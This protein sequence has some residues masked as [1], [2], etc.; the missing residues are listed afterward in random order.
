[1]V[2]KDAIEKGEWAKITELT[3][4]AV[5][6]MLGFEL[7]HVGIN[8]GSPEKAMEDATM[9]AKFLG[10]EINDGAGAAFVGNGFE[11]LKKPFKGT[12]GHLAIATNSV[13]RAKW[14]LERRGFQFEDE[15]EASYKDGKLYAIYLKNEIAGFAVHLLQ[16]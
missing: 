14:H 6:K 1:M 13:V 15:S 16:K 4:S 5:N 8:S 7:R 9:L 10:W 3:R 11:V 12:H 2:P